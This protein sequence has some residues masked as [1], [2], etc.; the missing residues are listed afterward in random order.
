MLGHSAFR[1][2][3]C[4][5]LFILLIILPVVV[6]KIWTNLWLTTPCPRLGLAICVRVL[7]NCPWVLIIIRWV[8]AVV[9]KLCLIRL[10]LFR[11]NNLRLMNMYASWLLTV[12]RISVVVMV[13]LILLDSL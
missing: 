6:L 1:I 5:L 8:F 7:R 12:C 13:E 4:M 3:K 10:I 2:K 11:C 9:M